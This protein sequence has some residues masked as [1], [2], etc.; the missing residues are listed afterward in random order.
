VSGAGMADSWALHDGSGGKEMLVLIYIIVIIEVY[1]EEASPS[2]PQ[3][4]LARCWLDVSPP[5]F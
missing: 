5:F 4:H 2:H 3:A 1:L